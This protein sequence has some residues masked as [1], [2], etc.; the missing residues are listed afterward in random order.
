MRE[1]GAGFKEWVGRGIMKMGLKT[2]G[3]E[4]KQSPNDIRTHPTTP[5]YPAWLWRVDERGRVRFTYRRARRRILSACAWHLAH[6]RHD[7]A[8]NSPR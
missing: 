7:P 4:C 5:A 2:L 8:F 3:S 6:G 1:N